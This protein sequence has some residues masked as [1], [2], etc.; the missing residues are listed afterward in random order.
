MVD[1]EELGGPESS[2]PQMEAD[3][4]DNPQPA[5]DDGGDVI[6][7]EEENA[8]LRDIPELEDSSPGGE[9]AVVF[10]GMAEL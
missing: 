10:G 8:L 5:P 9:T 3:T 6:S 7:P 2:G 1:K 4:E